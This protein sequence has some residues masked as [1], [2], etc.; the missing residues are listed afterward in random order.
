MK[1]QDDPVKMEVEHRARHR[2]PK[3]TWSYLGLHK[4]E[5]SS[6]EPSKQVWLRHAMLSQFQ[7]W[8]IKAQ[9]LCAFNWGS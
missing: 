3:D 5:G 8:N 9:F 2:K 1:T 4:V 7:I 6:P